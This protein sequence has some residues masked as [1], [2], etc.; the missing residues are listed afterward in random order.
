M[1]RQQ[2]KLIEKQNKKLMDLM[3]KS[4]KQNQRL[5]MPQIVKGLDVTD[6]MIEEYTQYIIKKRKEEQDGM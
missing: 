3:S 4:I 1:N 5:T 6:D 2:R